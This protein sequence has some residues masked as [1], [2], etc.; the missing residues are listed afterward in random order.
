MARSQGGQRWRYRW[1]GGVAH[2]HTAFV[3]IETM[4][5]Q[6]EFRVNAQGLDQRL[7]S[8][9]TEA[10]EQFRQCVARGAV[11]GMGRHGR[12]ECRDENR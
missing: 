11:R 5:G 4:D 10:L 2:R 6:D 7:F 3:R 12:R 8:R 9:R 1:S